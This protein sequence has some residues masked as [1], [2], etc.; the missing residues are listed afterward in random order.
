MMITLVSMLNN[1][2]ADVTRREIFDRLINA[3]REMGVRTYVSADGKGFVAFNDSEAI[4]VK[5]SDYE[6]EVR[7]FT[8]VKNAMSAMALMDVI[9]DSAGIDINKFTISI[10]SCTR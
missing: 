3:F 6:I 9:M 2:G 5:F 8:D 10:D 4:S 1:F 7:V